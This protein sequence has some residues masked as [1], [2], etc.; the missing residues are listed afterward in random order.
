MQPRSTHRGTTLAVSNADVRG[1]LH[2]CEPHPEH[3]HPDAKPLDVII[4]K[5]TPGTPSSRRSLLP[6]LTSP[7]PPLLRCEALHP[8]ILHSSPLRFV[9]GQAKRES[10]PRIVLTPY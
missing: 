2:T 3:I 7:L 1:S 4:P 10:S 6:A 8:S 9:I 5:G